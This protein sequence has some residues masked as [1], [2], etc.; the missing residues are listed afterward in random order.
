MLAPRSLGRDPETNREI[1]LLHL[2]GV[3]DRSWQWHSYGH[4]V[5]FCA[6]DARE[7]ADQ[8]IASF[9]S[10]LLQ[11]GCAYF[12]AWGPDCE[13]VHDFMD[14]EALH[15]VPQPYGSAVVMTTW[16]ANDDLESALNF[17]LDCTEPDERYAPEGC[18][19]SLVIVIGRPDWSAAADTFIG[20]ALRDRAQDVKEQPPQ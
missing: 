1:Y 19:N 6:M 4:F 5:C 3:Q 13:R 9:C 18:A 10:H 15:V 16:H 11:L 17:L 8:E 12:C 7:V 2:D 20:L 14:R